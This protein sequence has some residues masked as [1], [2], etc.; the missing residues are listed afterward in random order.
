MQLYTIQ[1]KKSKSLMHF[2]DETIVCNNINALAYIVD[3]VRK[4]VRFASPSAVAVSQELQIVEV[5]T[6][7]VVMEIPKQED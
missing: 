2:D 4:K 7:K 1:S 3:S 5:D 6:R